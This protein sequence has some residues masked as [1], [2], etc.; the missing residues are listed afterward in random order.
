MV[1]NG[2]TILPQEELA[3]EPMVQNLMVIM[4]SEFAP[5]EMMKLEM[6]LKSALTTTPDN[7]R[8]VVVIFLPTEAI[9][10]TIIV[11][12]IAPRK[13]PNPIKDLSPRII[14]RVAP[15]VAPADIPNIYGSQMGLLTVVCI[16]LPQSARPAPAMSPIITRGLR[17][18]H[19]IAIVDFAI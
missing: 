7:T 5:M 2:M 12:M 19:T 8:L 16:V 13:A 14:K 4:L 18:F 3:R 9:I 15:K 17:I 1:M 11:A 10:N 6:A